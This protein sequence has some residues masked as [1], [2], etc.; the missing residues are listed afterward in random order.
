[1]NWIFESRRNRV[2]RILY[3]RTETAEKKSIL[4]RKN[5]TSAY[6]IGM[7]IENSLPK[8]VAACF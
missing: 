2:A 3:S 7:K 1:M 5:F 4:K 6:F 8:H